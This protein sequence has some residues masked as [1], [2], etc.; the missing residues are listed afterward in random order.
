MTTRSSFLRRHKKAVLGALVIAWILALL[1]T[2]L[3]GRDLPPGLLNLGDTVLHSVGFFCL[4]SLFWLTLAAYNVRLAHRVT[5]VLCAM[6][7]YAAVDETTQAWVNRSPEVADWLAD[8]TGVLLAVTILEVGRR[9]VFG[10]Q[11]R[12]QAPPNPYQQ[13]PF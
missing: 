10:P 5:T 4:A 7:I 2:H 8:V 11:H 9:L 6:M 1:A 3:P 13:H 12:V